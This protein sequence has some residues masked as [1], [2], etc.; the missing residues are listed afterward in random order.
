[1]VRGLVAP[2]M[3]HPDGSPSNRHPDMSVL[4]QH[5]AFFDLD[6]NGIVYPWETFAGKFIPSCDWEF[7][8]LFQQVN[9]YICR[10][11]KTWVQYCCINWDDSFHQPELELPYTPCM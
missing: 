9:M 1:M 8:F 2:D 11:P 7:L 10:I 3:E 6:N 5:V 4:Q